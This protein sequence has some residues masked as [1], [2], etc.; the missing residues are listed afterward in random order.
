MHG[1]KEGSAMRRGSLLGD[2]WRCPQRACFRA[3]KYEAEIYI[4]M[5]LGREK[6]TKTQKRKRHGGR[7]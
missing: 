6:E 7:D 3:E 4:Y 1:I 5:A 2:R